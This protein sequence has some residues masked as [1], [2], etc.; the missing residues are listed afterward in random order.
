MTKPAYTT[1]ETLSRARD[2]AADLLQPLSG[3]TECVDRALRV[4]ERQR[5]CARMARAC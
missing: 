1:E 5:E 3:I 4:E 2:R